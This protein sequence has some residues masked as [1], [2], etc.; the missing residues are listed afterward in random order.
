MA[1][2]LFDKSELV[3]K[4]HFGILVDPLRVPHPLDVACARDAANAKHRW[5]PS[6]HHARRAAEARATA[7]IALR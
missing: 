3:P 4:N 5:L 7:R 6:Q 2:H 1:V